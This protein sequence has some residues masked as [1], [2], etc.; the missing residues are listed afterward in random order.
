MSR[1]ATPSASASRRTATTLGAGPR[2]RRRAPG[3]TPHDTVSL[4]AASG[5]EGDLSV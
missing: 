1:Q 4:A 2:T 3:R 5:S